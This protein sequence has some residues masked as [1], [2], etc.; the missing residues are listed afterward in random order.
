[1]QLVGRRLETAELD[2]RGESREL[3]RIQ[4]GLTEPAQ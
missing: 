2:Y 3:A 1:M 4:A